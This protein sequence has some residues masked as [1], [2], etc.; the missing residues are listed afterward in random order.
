MAYVNT[1]ISG[2][3]IPATATHAF[4]G[5]HDPLLERL[6]EVITAHARRARIDDATAAVMLAN[7]EM[8]RL[9]APAHYQATPAPPR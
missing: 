5:D 9:P 2:E 1:S 4:I 7:C 6:W 8:P 3:P